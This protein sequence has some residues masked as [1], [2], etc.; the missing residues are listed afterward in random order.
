MIVTDEERA[1][2][3]SDPAEENERGLAFV[4]YQSRIDFGF[5]FIQ[6][7][8]ANTETFPPGKLSTPG[9]DAIIGANHGQSRTMGGYD[10]DDT[11]RELTLLQDFVVSKGGEYFFSPSIEALRDVISV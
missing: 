6:T 9:F 2:N 8:W 4:A 7:R 1:N 10:V 11:T 3:A 5:Q